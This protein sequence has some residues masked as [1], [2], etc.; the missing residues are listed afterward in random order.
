[1]ERIIANPWESIQGMIASHLHL[2][3]NLLSF[4]S[5]KTFTT[6]LLLREVSLYSARL[7]NPDTSAVLWVPGKVAMSKSQDCGLEEGAHQQHSQG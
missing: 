1:M 3:G 5:H 7:T 6:F 4:V 2:K